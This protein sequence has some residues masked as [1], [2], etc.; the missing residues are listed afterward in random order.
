[1]S[2]LHL[3]SGAGRPGTWQ[4][5]SQLEVEAEVRHPGWG[6]QQQAEWPG[7]HSAPSLGTGLGS[8]AHLARGFTSCPKGH[9]LQVQS[10]QAAF[11]YTGDLR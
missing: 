2:A 3:T 8:P 5:D 9:F 11:L 4:R 6:A 10:T 7:T 1:M